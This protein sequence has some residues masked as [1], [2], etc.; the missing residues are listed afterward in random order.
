MIHRAAR[1]VDGEMVAEG[2]EGGNPFLQ[3]Q[4][5]RRPGGQK[6]LLPGVAEVPCFERR[7]LHVGV[8]TWL[9]SGNQAGPNPQAKTGAIDNTEIFPLQ[10]TV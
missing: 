2:A 8:V 10:D 9:Q 3:A 7:F 1:R 4:M 6:W 5:Y